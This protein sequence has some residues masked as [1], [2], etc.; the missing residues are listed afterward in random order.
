MRAHVAAI[1]RDFK[2]P[3]GIEPGLLAFTPEDE[4]LLLSPVNQSPHSLGVTDRSILACDQRSS[5]G[6]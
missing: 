3:P 5:D 2:A 6:G 1:R 4:H